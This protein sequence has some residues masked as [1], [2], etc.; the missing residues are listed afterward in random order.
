MFPT[1]SYYMSQLGALYLAMRIGPRIRNVV[2]RCVQACILASGSVSMRVYLLFV[3]KFH[4][5]MA[6]CSD[7]VNSDVVGSRFVI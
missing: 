5:L 7:L 4:F 6:L 1:L 3:H 2:H